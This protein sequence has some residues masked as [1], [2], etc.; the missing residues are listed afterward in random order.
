MVFGW[1]DA[2]VFPADEIRMAEEEL[3]CI[4]GDQW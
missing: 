4:D 3:G 1:S 2:G